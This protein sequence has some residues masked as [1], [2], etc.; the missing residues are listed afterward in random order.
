MT[1]K[2]KEG[3]KQTDIEEML[4]IWKDHFKKHL[5]T[6]FPHKLDALNQM[7]EPPLTEVEDDFVIIKDKIRKTNSAL[8]PRKSPGYDVITAEVL[9][10]GGEETV[11]RMS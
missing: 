5:N 3:N 11:V 8:K 4:T 7:P 1:V 9:E 6:E 10:A 2:D